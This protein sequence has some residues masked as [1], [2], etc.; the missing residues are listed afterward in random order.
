MSPR[1]CV[2]YEI[3][4][5]CLRRVGFD[6]CARVVYVSRCRRVAFDFFALVVY[7][8]C[9]ACRVCFCACC[10]IGSRA[11]RFALRWRTLHARA[12]V[13]NSEMITISL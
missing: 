10:V 2:S 13:V 11:C 8:V 5:I 6:I 3:P 7:V 1:L 9:S 12:C 4:M